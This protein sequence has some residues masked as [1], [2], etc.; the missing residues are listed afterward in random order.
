MS[1]HADWEKARRKHVMKMRMCVAA[2][3][4]GDMAAAK[5][6]AVEA[7]EANTELGRIT[8]ELDQENQP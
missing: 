5:A 8:T 2:V 7:D 6:W 1:T 3:L 4:S